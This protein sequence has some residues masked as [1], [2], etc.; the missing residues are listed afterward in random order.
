[1]K[2]LL[3]IVTETTKAEEYKYWKEYIHSFKYCPNCGDD[4]K[5][6]HG[7]TPE[8]GNTG[9]SDNPIISTLLRLCDKCIN[10]V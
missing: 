3:S 2:H 6:S 10:N 1:M 4:L 5:N 9:K 7:S 8:H